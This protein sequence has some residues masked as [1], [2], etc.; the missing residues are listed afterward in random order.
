VDVLLSHAPPLGVGDDDDPAHVG[1]QA[2]HT[3]VAR[4]SPSFLL[5][6]H[7]HPYGERKTD[8]MMGTTQVVNVIPRRVLEVPG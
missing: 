4:L 8:R 1:I 5:H 2:L 7:I 6:G 3:L